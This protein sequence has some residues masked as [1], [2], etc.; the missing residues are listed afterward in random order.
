MY[1]GIRKLEERG[2]NVLG[3]Q[4]GGEVFKGCVGGLGWV[5]AIVEMGLLAS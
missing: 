2:G 5:T 3:A 1:G 4:E